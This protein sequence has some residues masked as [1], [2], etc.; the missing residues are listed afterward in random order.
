M[1]RILNIL[2][3]GAPASAPDAG[4]PRRAD[5]LKGWSIEVMPRTAAKVADFTALLP[6]GTLVYIAHID[7]T[8]F[9][10]M[11][12]TARRLRSEGFAVMPHIPARSV[13]SRETLDSWLAAYAA[14]GIDSA[15]VLA[16]GR[17][18]PAGPFNSSRALLETGLFEQHGFTRLH[19]AGHP[20]GNR[21]ICE[22]TEAPL[23]EALLWKQDF[24]ARTGIDMCIV[25]QFAFEAQPVLDWLDRLTAAGI[26]LPVQIGIAGPAKLQTLIRY[27]M[28]C[29]VG[30][31]LKVLQ[32]RAADLTRLVQ[33]FAP[34]DILDGLARHQATRPE[35][36]LKG[37]HLFPLGGI[38]A[39][40]KY[41]TAA[42]SVAVPA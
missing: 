36:L 29:G 40:A 18:D 22:G 11:E 20:E 16:G 21:D 5:L 10:E 41:A 32:K 25:T 37:V 33:P 31:S 39:S 12:A 35:G 13:P 23:M 3:G 42:Q 28:A 14:L 17:T 4:A 27:G 6:E 1:S 19:V 8:P 38:T 9:E 15:L 34:D 7:G 30:A 24:A 26:T 2:R